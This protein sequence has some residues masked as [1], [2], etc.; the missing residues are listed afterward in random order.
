MTTV[1]QFYNALNG[2]VVTGVKR[3]FTAPPRQLATAD[4]PAQ[5]VNLPGAANNLN[6]GLASTCYSL[7]KT[8]TATL[9]IATEAAGQNNNPTN[10]AGVLTMM[11]A[12]ETA[13]D[14]YRKTAGMV[15][16]SITPAAI[17]LSETNYWGVTCTVTLEG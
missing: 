12:L 7:A 1:T 5:W 15:D 11:D 17:V 10:T 9:V 2:L 6:S 16:Y 14:N 13:L 3:R 4:L 8:R